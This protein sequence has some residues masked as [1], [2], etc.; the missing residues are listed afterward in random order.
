MFHSHPL[1]LFLLLGLILI[2]A[3]FQIQASSSSESSLRRA[4]IFTQPLF[5][6]QMKPLIEELIGF[7]SSA[8]GN[9][10]KQMDVTLFSPYDDVVDSFQQYL[11]R[12][13][14]AVS[15]SQTFRVR[16]C[17]AAS[18]GVSGSSGSIKKDNYY[19]SIVEHGLKKQTFFEYAE[20]MKRE[21]MDPYLTNSMF[22]CGQEELE[23]EE[24]VSPDVVVTDCH[25]IGAMDFAFGFEKPLV[26]VCP[27][28]A[29]LSLIQPT[30][31][32]S[33]K[34]L[35]TRFNPFNQI[36][37]LKLLGELTKRNTPTTAQWE[38]IMAN[39]VKYLIGSADFSNSTNYYLYMNKQSW[40]GKS[41][42][43]ISNYFSQAQF[44][45]FWLRDNLMNN[46]RN[47]YL[48]GRVHDTVKPLDVVKRGHVFYT[49]IPGVTEDESIMLP[50]NAKIVPPIL[51]T[52]QVKWIALPEKRLSE[53]KKLEKLI[54]Y[55]NVLLVNLRDSFKLILTF[56][57]VLE[58]LAKKYDYIVVVNR[59]EVTKNLESK[60]PSFTFS[61][62]KVEERSRILK[63]PAI[64]FVITSG[65]LQSSIEALSH[66]KL[67][68][69][70]P[71]TIEGYTVS[72][73]LTES[74]NVGNILIPT[75]ATEEIIQNYLANFFIPGKLVSQ[76]VTTRIISNRFVPDSN[77]AVKTIAEYVNALANSPPL[78][79]ASENSNETLIVSLASLAACLLVTVLIVNYFI[80]KWV[81]IPYVTL[82]LYCCGFRKHSRESQVSAEITGEAK[83]KKD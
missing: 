62:L 38:K 33:G 53:V 70:I 66:E 67:L 15:S 55:K 46:A 26:I 32:Q 7:S 51:Y 12:K 19:T 50:S 74:L 72:H 43:F 2:S 52:K 6:D 17:G 13:G 30:Y 68:S 45:A 81:I 27:T 16:K 10:S 60:Y 64:K 48:P 9:S 37:F 20:Y 61:D 3:V 59:N 73:Y 11:P 28:L 47:Q 76:T 63:N 77:L 18:G 58:K 79:T 78:P 29:S 75:L 82:C 44:E 22:T 39:S 24:I 56:F 36:L 1:K 49:S 14:S 71:S 40:V 5:Y 8:H 54:E 25:S 23:K 41:L 57:N 69:L 21:W 4:W 42:N 34:F 83:Q 35:Q 65:D 31:Y 80:F